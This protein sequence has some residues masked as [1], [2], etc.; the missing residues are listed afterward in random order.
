MPPS[1][2]IFAYDLIKREEVSV[3]LCSH[4]FPYQWPQYFDTSQDDTMNPHN[5]RYPKDSFHFSY[6][7]EKWRASSAGERKGHFQMDGNEIWSECG[8]WTIG[9]N[10]DPWSPT[11]DMRRNLIDDEK[12]D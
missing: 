4:F 10:A 5:F 7:K 12:P 1:T 3:R 8:L 2:L 6:L 11:S 9:R